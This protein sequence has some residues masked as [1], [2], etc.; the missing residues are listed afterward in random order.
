MYKI[1][2]GGIGMKVVISDYPSVMGRPLEYEKHILEEGLKDCEVVVHLYKNQDEFIDVIKD[3]DALLTA[4]LPIN[5]K[6][7]AHA[8]KLKCI[9]YNS[10]GYDSTDYEEATKRNIAIIPIA[11]YC[12]QEVAEHTMA[13]ILALTRNIK[14]YIKDIDER[15]VWKY[16]SG[17]LL[18]SLHDQ[19]LGIVGFGKIGK[20]VAIRAAAFGMHIKVYDERVTKEMLVN[21]KV[22][23]GQ[24]DRVS[25]E[26]LYE[27]SDVITNHMNLTN[28]NQHFFNKEAFKK[29][30]R[31]PIFINVS[32][33]GCVDEEALVWALDEGKILA[34]GIDV[35]EAENPDLEK[36][37][38]RQRENVI[39]TPH[40]AFYS[41]ASIK[42]LQTISC[43]NVVHY[44]NK[45][46]DK[47]RRIVNPITLL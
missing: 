27:T 40:A 22:A 26:E 47:V 13:L 32:R 20:A 2:T 16:Y 14:H 21:L 15:K 41:A 46:Y 17:G 29:M 1:E 34:A 44:L 37:K 35:L 33:G 11:E 6:V 31:Q 43:E 4:F 45:E 18:R 5:Q 38:L 12:T 19:T 10:T 42:A 3:A 8:K 28:Q 30:K 9:G 25:I 36:C 7:L 24:I 23:D 39:I